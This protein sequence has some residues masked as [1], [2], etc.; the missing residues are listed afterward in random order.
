MVFTNTVP[1]D[2]YR[3]PGRAEC[4][5]MTERVIDVAARELGLSP[6]ELRRRNLIPAE[7]MPYRSPTGVLYDSG[8]F[9]AVF[10][11]ALQHADWAGFERRRAEAQ[12]RNRL[13]GRGIACYIDQTGMGP[14]RVLIDRGMKIPSYESALV[15]LNKDCGVTVVTGTHSHGQGL[16]T[17]LAQ[18]V[19]ERLG[20]AL[21]DVEVLHG[22]TQ[23]LGY[24][25]GTV[26]AR[27]LLSGGAALE[28][29]L[30]KVIEK[31]RRI[32]AHALEC[33][34]QDL[35]FEGGHYTIRGTDR[36]ISLG[37]VARLAYFPGDYPIEELEPGLEETAYWDPKAVAFPNGCH[38]C[39]V[40]IDPDTGVLNIASYACVDDFGNIVNPLLVS[41]QVHGGVA[42]GLGQ[43]A[44]RAL[45]L[46]GDYQRPTAHRFTDGL[47]PAARRRPSLDHRRDDAR[48]AMHDQSTRRQGLRRGRHH[49][50]TARLGE[51][52]G[53]CASAVR[54]AARRHAGD[55]GEAV[56]VDAPRRLSGTAENPCNSS[57]R[58]GDR[59]AQSSA[60]AR[61]RA[62]GPP[63]PVRLS[64][65]PC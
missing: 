11:K 28:A 63:A 5:Y 8:D 19:V 65:V 61:R 34:A 12:Q 24:G 51:R 37:E 4:G 26:G 54:R 49:R 15:R 48:P 42:Q 13:R 2:A 57:A 52:G 47:L 36:T 14:S 23:A 39:E 50:R 40:E 53:R 27:S 38:V 58:P 22:D 1:T 43:G 62:C 10:E 64:P 46:R 7:S 29:A 44:P 30:G 16:E 56:A 9:P 21:T 60:T 6:V 31:G 32:A 3:A 45:P 25:R 41:G 20:V 35:A 59:S 17:A 33:A 18:I 55:R